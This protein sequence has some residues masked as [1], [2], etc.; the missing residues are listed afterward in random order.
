MSGHGIDRRGL[1]AGGAG[2]AVLAAAGTGRMAS[3]A[4][5]VA[6]TMMSARDFGAV[7][8]GVADD[9]EAL[10]RVFEAALA[11]RQAAL[12][13]IPPGRYRVTRT[14]GVTSGTSPEGNVT[15][16]AGI[17]AQG[18]LLISEIR[19]GA[20]VIKIE[21]RAVIR[22]FLIEGLQIKGSGQDGHGLHIECQTRGTY[23]YNF[24]LRDLIVEGCGG[25]GCNLTGNIFEGQIFNSYFRDNKGNGATFSHGEQNTVL[26]AVHCFGCVF[27]GNGVNGVKMVNG[28]QDVSFHG[29]YFLLNK[30][31]GLSARSGCTL[32]SNCGFEN[33]HMHAKNFASGGAGIDLMVFGTLI[34]CTGYSIYRQT[35]LIRAFVT[36]RLVMI[37]CTGE[38]DGDADQARLATLHGKSEASVTLVGCY[39]GVDRQG[40]LSA[41][42]F[43]AVGGS[44]HFGSQW[45]SS[46]LAWLGDHCLWV[47]G[48]GQLRIKRGAP[49]RDDDGSIVGASS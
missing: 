36:N 48:K 4:T 31:Y 3:S 13:V 19:G 41:L 6:T 35:H 46:G 17:L 10:Q 32:L 14:I 16:R 1:F 11:G 7:G 2:L 47:D 8:N 22:Y 30:Y 5:P 45:D 20:P 34:G 33:N 43:G 27:G 24:C 15:Q 25:D 21:S 40:K 44:A 18:A 39:G 42:E 12:V 28:A 49:R 26:S 37:G 23:F 38:G 9:T 29:C